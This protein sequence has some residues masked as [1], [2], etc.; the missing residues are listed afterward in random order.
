MVT[1]RPRG[2]SPDDIEEAFENNTT[3]FEAC[4]ELR[5][6]REQLKILVWEY[7][8]ARPD[9]WWCGSPQMSK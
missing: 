1:N 9:Y 3:V 7:D 2:I 4:R 5:I 6:S 8:V